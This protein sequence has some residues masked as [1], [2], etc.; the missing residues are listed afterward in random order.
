MEVEEEE[1]EVQ[2]REDAPAITVTFRA[3]D[4]AGLEP[5]ITLALHEVSDHLKI[6]KYRV[7]H[8]S[9]QLPQ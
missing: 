2:V 9:L 3:A 8:M 4:N 1:V 5:H 6:G 7:W